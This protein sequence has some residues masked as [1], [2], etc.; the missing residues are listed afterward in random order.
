MNHVLLVCGSTEWWDWKPI[1][2][3]LRRFPPGTILRHG[4]ARGADRMAGHVGER[5]GFVV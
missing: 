3:S 2:T 5:L 4:N 1:W